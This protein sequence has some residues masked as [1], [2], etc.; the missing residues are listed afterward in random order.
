LSGQSQTVTRSEPFSQDSEPIECY[1]CRTPLDI[2]RARASLPAGKWL[3]PIQ[4]SSNPK[5]KQSHKRLGLVLGPAMVVTLAALLSQR[6]N[7]NERLVEFAGTG[8]LAGVQHMLL[9]KRINPNS[10]PRGRTALGAAAEQGSI[11]VVRLLLDSGADP[12]AK[13]ASGGTALADSLYPDKTSR[14]R[15]T[16]PL[17]WRRSEH[18]FISYAAA[19]SELRRLEGPGAG[20]VTS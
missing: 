13:D 16:S 6:R 19:H 7:P 20:R 5:R 2:T 11:D 1:S 12:N 4:T 15:E 3:A 14:S 17:P 9:N 8:N 18:P 10:T